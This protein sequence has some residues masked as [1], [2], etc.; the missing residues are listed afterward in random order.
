MNRKLK[1]RYRIIR[2][3]GYMFGRHVSGAYCWCVP[4]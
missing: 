4:D 1:L 2:R 3:I